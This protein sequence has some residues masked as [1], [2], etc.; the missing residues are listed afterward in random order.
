MLELG[1]G[2]DDKMLRR[3][4]LGW[5]VRLLVRSGCNQVVEQEDHM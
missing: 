5:L 1:L 3:I 2:F 4:F